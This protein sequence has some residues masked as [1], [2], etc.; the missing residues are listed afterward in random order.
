MHCTSINVSL[1]NVAELARVQTHGNEH[2]KKPINFKALP[3]SSIVSHYSVLHIDMT[4]T[5]SFQFLNKV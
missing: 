4:G 5:F 3:A 2:R 1:S